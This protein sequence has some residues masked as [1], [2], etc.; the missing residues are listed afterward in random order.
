LA[1][2]GATLETELTEVLGVLQPEADETINR[3]ARIAK[4]RFKVLE[5]I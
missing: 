2:A 5:N 4:E 3:L 1:R